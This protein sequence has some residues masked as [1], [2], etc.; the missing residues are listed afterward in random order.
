VRVKNNDRLEGLTIA[1]LP[2]DAAL[3]REVADG[4]NAPEQA[5]LPAKLL[6]DDLGC[7]LFDRICELPEYYPTRTERA[8]LQAVAGDIARRTQ[9]HELV[10]LGSG[11][12]RK[13]HVLLDALGARERPFRYLPFDVSPVVIRASAERLRQRY[14][15]LSVHGVVGDFTRHLKSIPYGNRRIVAFLGGTIGN[16]DEEQARAFIGEL[17]RQLGPSD[18]LLLAADL[19]KDRA[20][21]HDAY[22]DRAGVTAA[23][24]LNALTRLRRE[25]QFQI[26]PADFVHD[27]FF[28]EARSRIEIHAR[29]R[30][31]TRVHAPELRV[32][33]TLKAGESIRTEISRKF[34]RPML[35]TMLAEAR[36]QIEMLY[37]APLP[38]ALVLARRIDTRAKGL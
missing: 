30:V 22:N 13:T 11:H 18:A 9:A 3:R 29:A 21:L 2:S 14:P 16:F 8:L 33:R 25:L 31:Q 32:D 5:T 20:Q 12:A 23:F 26:E 35:E 17:A 1:A 10:E 4:L 28:S 38:Y 15:R 27:A 34:T 6:Y 7:D 37:E 36:L 19:V 24:N